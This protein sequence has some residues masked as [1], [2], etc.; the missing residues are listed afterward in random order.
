ME[1][2]FQL[3]VE[4]IKIGA[5]GGDLGDLGHGRGGI[6]PQNGFQ[7]F[8]GSQPCVKDRPKGCA[9]GPRCAQFTPE[10]EEDIP[11]R[12]VRCGTV[13]CLYAK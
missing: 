11:E 8:Q 4:L 9:F 13:R 3:G 6:L 10:C 7:P 5:Q 12:L 1:Q 2:A